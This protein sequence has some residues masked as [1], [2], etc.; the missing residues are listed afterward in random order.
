M[1]CARARSPRGRARGSVPDWSAASPRRARPGCS[2]PL[3]ALSPPPPGRFPGPTLAARA[4]RRRRRPGRRRRRADADEASRR[5]CRSADCRRSSVEATVC[6]VSRSP[7]EHGLGEHVVEDL[8]LRPCC[9]VLRRPGRCAHAQ[10]VEHARLPPP[11]R[12]TA[13]RARSPARWAIFVPDGVTR[14]LYI[15]AAASCSC[16]ERIDIARSRCSSTIARSLLRARA[17]CRAGDGR[18]PRS[19][20]TF[21]KRSSTS[22][23]YGASIRPRSSA[24][25]SAPPRPG[26]AELDLSCADRVEDLVDELV[27]GDD[28][29]ASG[30]RARC[31]APAA[32]RSRG[33]RRGRSSRSSRSELP[34]RF[35]SCVLNASS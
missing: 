27:L 7:G 8:V 29:L 19:R 26:C 35:G 34:K 30:R 24:A 2:R 15:A 31:T 23:R 32:P 21:Q 22:W 9:A 33:S 1:E 5:R 20:S 25:S 12:P 4:R 3:P 13:Y 10:P 18:E 14:W 16:G 11:R 28:G 17:A 6:L